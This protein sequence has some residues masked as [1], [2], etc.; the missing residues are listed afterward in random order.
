MLWNMG[1]LPGTGAREPRG[2]HTPHPVVNL[3]EKRVKGEDPGKNLIMPGQL[4][5]LW[6][7]ATEVQRPAGQECWFES[8]P[9]PSV[10]GERG[11]VHVSGQLL[12][13]ASLQLMV[14]SCV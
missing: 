8:R 6:Y 4:S 11:M 3:E 5:F 14:N 9:C 12:N 13:H 7:S 2:G 1:L 10:K